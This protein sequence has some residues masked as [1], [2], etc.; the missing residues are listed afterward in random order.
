MPK[1]ESIASATDS[2]LLTSNSSINLT[3]LLSSEF[4][5]SSYSGR[6]IS[7]KL[8]P[9]SARVSNLFESLEVLSSKSKTSL[10]STLMYILKKSPICF[11]TYATGILIKSLGTSSEV[12]DS[13]PLLTTV[14]NSFSSN[15]LYKVPLRGESFNKEASAGY[16]K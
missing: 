3:V 4:I 8:S 9:L 16:S 12:L 6:S 14:V 13:N 2:G 1:P 7:I 10:L 11:S 15:G 5:H